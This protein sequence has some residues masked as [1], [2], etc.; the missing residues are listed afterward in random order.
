MNANW[1]APAET[2][3]IDEPQKD[4]SES[5]ENEPKFGEFEE[6]KTEELP[7]SIIEQTQA[8]DDR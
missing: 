3:E 2:Q 1:E 6:S 5:S 8:E 7:T 4:Q